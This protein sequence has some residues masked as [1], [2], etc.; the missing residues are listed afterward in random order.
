MRRIAFYLFYDAVGE[1]DDYIPFKLSALQEFVKDIIVVCNS[2]ITESGRAKLES[3]GVKIF[4]RENIGFDVWGYKEG[5]ELIGYDQLTSSYDEVILL[6]YTFFGPIFPFSE[7]FNEMDK[8]TCDFWGIS[9]HSEITPNPFTGRGTLPRHIQ[10]HFIAIRS[11]MLSSLEF[12]KYWLEMPMINSYEDSVLTHES[13][14][15]SYFEERGFSSSV[16]INE[17]DYPSVYPTFFDIRETI[18]NRS[19]I[20]KR[21]L[22]FHDP[23]WMEDNYVDLRETLDVIKKTSDYNLDLIIQNVNRSVKPRDL[24]SNLE[25]LRILPTDYYLDDCNVETKENVAVIVHVDNIESWNE[26]YLFIKKI[27]IPFD[28][29]ISTPNECDINILKKFAYEIDVLT[30]I[31]IVDKTVCNDISTLF[32]TFNDVGLNDKYEY[33]CRLHTLSVQHYNSE[34]HQVKKI[35][36]VKQQCLENLL[37]TPEYICNVLKLMQH[38]ADVGIVCPPIMHIG[39]PTMGH[40]WGETKPQVGQL[41][42]ELGITVPL[43]TD[44]PMAVYGSMFWFK[45][46]ALRS[47]FKHNWTSEAL[48]D[49]IVC[50]DRYMASVFGR[51]ICYASKN[52]GYSIYNVMTAKQAERNYVKL[53]LK[54]QKI[55]S[56]LPTGDVNWQYTSLKNIFGTKN[57]YEHSMLSILSG[58]VRLS[59]SVFKQR[60]IYKHP[61]LAKRLRGPYLFTKKCIKQFQ[62]KKNRK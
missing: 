16:Y 28:L 12:R 40:A 49:E 34:W 8:R 43:D 61:K 5:L 23:V 59:L 26:L 19:P 20:L 3:I 50:N 45:P 31:R 39:L 9:D 62:S 47:L 10:S 42:K 41:C 60:L 21:R 53:E 38:S 36:M 32:I 13:R 55:M 56:T 22:F 57:G 14:F 44:T 27:P 52:E 37:A 15:T 11:K 6:N 24:Y 25:Q 51:L 7:L 18:L 2:P 33:I 1:V 29:Y 48:S 35:D 4:C 58:C 54:L 46:P 17:K 30:D